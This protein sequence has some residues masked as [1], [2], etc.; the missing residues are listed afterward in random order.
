M[1]CI[2]SPS[3]EASREIC[4]RKALAWSR[5][6]AATWLAQLRSRWMRKRPRSSDLSSRSH[7]EYGEPSAVGEI[8]MKLRRGEDVA[9][10][11]T[12]SATPDINIGN[13]QRSLF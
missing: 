6:P 4:S 12:S 2:V 13:S 11:E 8:D 10:E 5:L 1:R 9:D 3:G 7:G